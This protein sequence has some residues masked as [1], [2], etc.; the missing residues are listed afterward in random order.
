MPDRMR[1]THHTSGFNMPHCCN[2]SLSL[3]SDLNQSQAE[4][5]G[6]SEKNTETENETENWKVKLDLRVKSSRFVQSSQRN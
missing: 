2:K 1:L 5:L 3:T 4:E 6:R